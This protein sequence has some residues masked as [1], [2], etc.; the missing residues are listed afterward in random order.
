M[1]DDLRDRLADHL[2]RVESYP[3]GPVGGKFDDLRGVDGGCPAPVRPCGD[4]AGT[5]G[6][7]FDWTALV[8][9]FRYRDS[10][11]PR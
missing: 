1:T 6:L 9:P 5:A 10:Q 2:T 4:R 7:G 11:Y 3:L 8:Q